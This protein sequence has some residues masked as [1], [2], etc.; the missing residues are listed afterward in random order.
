MLLLNTK[1]DMNEIEL[2]ET[3]FVRNIDSRVFQGIVK[4]C[5]AQIEGIK[6]LESH[7]FTRLLPQSAVYGV[8]GI[9]VDQDKSSSVTIR[10]QVKICYGFSI[11]KKSD[12]IHQKVSQQVT[13]LTGVHVSAVR[14]HFKGL[15][16]EGR[17]SPP[18]FANET[19]E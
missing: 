19:L 17:I 10:I 14:V 16:Q 6:L 5:L 9:S 8:R 12:E 2:P 15:A 13:H 11:P 7:R 18:L 3:L 4:Q 1:M